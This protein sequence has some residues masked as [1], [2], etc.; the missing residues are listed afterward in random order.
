VE[1]PHRLLWHPNRQVDLDN[2][3]LLAWVYETVLCEAAS[4]SELEDW[5]DGATLIR[6]WPS[7]F[8]PRGVREAWE[9]RHPVLRAA[10]VVA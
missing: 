3:A 9:Q 5:L 6:L 4:V 1:L 10:T 7:I 8:V 2:A